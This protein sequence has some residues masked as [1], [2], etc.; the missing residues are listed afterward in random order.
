MR[1]AMRG[2]LTIE[3]RNAAFDAALAGIAN[4]LQTRTGRVVRVVVVHQQHFAIPAD[5]RQQ[6]VEVVRHASSQLPD[7]LHLL[8]LPQLRVHAYAIGHVLSCPD[9]PDR[10][11]ADLVDD[12]LGLPVNGA[13]R[14][15]IE[16][17]AIVVR[18]RPPLGDRL[19]NGRLDPRPIVGMH[20]CPERIGGGQRLVR[21]IAVHPVAFL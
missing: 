16:D 10:L 17:D 14:P 2:R 8:R 6:V 11:S 20:P 19:A 4:R 1:L 18:V 9:Q 15:V 12:D 5:D 3:T 21:S 13:L 7:R